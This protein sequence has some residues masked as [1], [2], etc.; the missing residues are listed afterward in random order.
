MKANTTAAAFQLASV[1]TGQ[2]LTRVVLKSLLHRNWSIRK[3]P[4]EGPDRVGVCHVK[5][6]IATQTE[7]II[8]D[9]IVE[10]T[11]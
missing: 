4:L 5:G 8:A 7:P 3:R 6:V 1:K 2:K 9:P 11:Q 10:E